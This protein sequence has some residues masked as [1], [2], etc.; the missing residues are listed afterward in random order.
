MRLKELGE[1]QR[2]SQEGL[3]MKLNVSQSTISAYEVGEKSSRFR[4]ANGDCKFLSCV[5]R[6]FGIGG[7]FYERHPIQSTKR[8]QTSI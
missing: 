2:L 8:R 4:N 3:A 6:L 5:V 1:Q 7:W